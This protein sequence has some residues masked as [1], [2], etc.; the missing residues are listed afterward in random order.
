MLRFAYLMSDCWLWISL[1]RDG[2]VTGQLDQVFR[3]FPRPRGNADLVSKFHYSLHASHVSLQFI[4]MQLYAAL[5]M[6][7][8]LIS[9]ICIICTKIKKR[10]YLG[11]FKSWYKFPDLPKCS[12]LHCL[13]PSLS[14]TFFSLSQSVIDSCY[15]W[16]L[17]TFR[18]PRRKQTS[19]AGSRYQRTVE[20]SIT[21]RSRM[22]KSNLWWF[23]KCSE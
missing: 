23:M 1:H 17:G 18:E 13:P 6:S 4:K 10:H 2:P 9:I 11:T 21:R 8:Q 19:C 7:Q 20:G 22:P 5:P 3:G 12:V 16:G 15:A 14:T